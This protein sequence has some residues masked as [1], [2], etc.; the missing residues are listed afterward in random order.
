MLHGVELYG[1]GHMLDHLGM[2][3]YLIELALYGSGVCFY[4]VCMS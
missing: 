1:L 2:K 4:A 3:W